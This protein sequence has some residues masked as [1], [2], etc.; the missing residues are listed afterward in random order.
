[1]KKYIVVLTLGLLILSQNALATEVMMKEVQPDP[2]EQSTQATTA[3]A[4][5]DDVQTLQSQNS[6]TQNVQ[7]AQAAQT[8]M[9]APTASVAPQLAEDQIPLKIES[10]EK[11]IEATS[12]GNKMMLSLVVMAVLLGAGYVFLRRYTVAN[13]GS[14]S[15]MQIKVLTQ[16]FLGPKKSLAIVRVAGESIL[17]GVTDNNISMIK[18]LSLLDDELPQ[19]DTKDFDQTMIEKTELVAQAEEMED[20][21]S[22]AGLKTTVAQKLKSMRSIQ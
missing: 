11:A 9:V 21:F 20:D 6:T 12:N 18:S 16:H 1:M 13:K 3:A 4:N 17:I 5:V 14:K 19:V 2:I 15:N 10:A 22:F 8:E 7:T